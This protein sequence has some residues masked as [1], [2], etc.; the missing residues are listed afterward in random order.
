MM[1]TQRTIQ[2]FGENCQRS[3]RENST[4][5]RKSPVNECYDMEKVVIIKVAC[6]ITQRRIDA[7][8]PAGLSMV[9]LLDCRVDTFSSILKKK[10]GK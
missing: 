4:A 1:M 3:P 7:V 10:L 2:K 5:K 9:S 6:S 8:E